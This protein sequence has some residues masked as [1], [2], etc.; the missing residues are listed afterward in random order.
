MN[1]QTQNKKTQKPKANL[2][3]KEIFEKTRQDGLK[4]LKD[5]EVRAV[6]KRL[7]DK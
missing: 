1:T 7:K 5:P 4:L 6:F 2:I 3:S